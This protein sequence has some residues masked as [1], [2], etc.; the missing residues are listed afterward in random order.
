MKRLSRLLTTT[1]ISAV[2]IQCLG[3]IPVHA[4]AGVAVTAKN[5]PD[6]NFRSV[7]ANIVCEGKGISSIKGIEF[8]TDIQGLWCADNNISEWD[9]S[10]NKDLRG[11]WCSGNDFTSLDFTDNPHLEW[12]YCFDCKLKSIIRIFLLNGT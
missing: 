5:F 1:I 12:V 10:N 4:A 9:L 6:A 2:S 8:F 3:G 11:I 7:I